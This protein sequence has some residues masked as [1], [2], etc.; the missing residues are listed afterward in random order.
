MVRSGNE[1][2]TARSPLRLRLVLA[3]FGVLIGLAG[4]VVGLAVRE[5]PVWAAS[6]VVLVV[7]L[8]DVAVV[9]TRIRQGPHYQPG[10][11]IPPYQVPPSSDRSALVRRPR[12]ARHRERVY[13]I[14][15]G[16][17]LTLVAVSWIW[18]RLVNTLAAVI[19]GAVAMVIPP[20]AAIVANLGWDADPPG[21]ERRSADRQ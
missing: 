14:L 9:R 15:M 2:S 8:I 5:R 18:L 19:V 1:P 20:V 11:D 17:C 16:V 21:P 3:L 4:L 10:S 6:G 12:R 7:A 13:L